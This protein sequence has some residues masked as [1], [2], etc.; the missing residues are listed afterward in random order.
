MRSNSGKGEGTNNNRNPTL[1]DHER[2]HG[3]SGEAIVGEK[4]AGSPA[5]RIA[6]KEKQGS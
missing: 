4:K 6:T 3:R 2:A 1:R 5:D